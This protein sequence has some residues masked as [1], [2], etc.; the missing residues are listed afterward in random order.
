MAIDRLKLFSVGFQSKGGWL[1]WWIVVLIGSDYGA[2]GNGCGC[3][4]RFGVV[5]RLCLDGRGEVGVRGR[6]LVAVAGN[7]SGGFWFLFLW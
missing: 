5:V 3:Y 1:S 4:D 6:E 2:I 7:G